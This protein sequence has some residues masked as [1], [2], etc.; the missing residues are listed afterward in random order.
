MSANDTRTPHSPTWSAWDALPNGASR[1]KAAKV[2][3]LRR[4]NEAGLFRTLRDSRWRSRRL[5]ILAY[6]GISLADEHEWSP[7]LYLPPEAIRARFELI[8]SQGYQ[9]LPLREAVEKLRA[10]TLPPRALAITFDDGTRDF[11]EAGV[12][13]LREFNYP[14]TVYVTSYYAEKQVPVFRM[15]ARY[16]VWRGRDR[17][18]SGEGLTNDG[19]PLDLHTLDHRDAAVQHMVD[20]LEARDGGVDDEL[21]TLRVLSARVGV[22]FDQ[23]LAE[24]RQQIMSPAEIRSL[25]SDL[26]EV[27][28]HTHRH[29]VP[30]RKASFDREIEDNRRALGSFRVGEKLDAFC[31]PSG[32][33]D[34]RFLPWLNELSVRT[35]VTCEAGLATASTDPLLLPRL[36]DTGL[37]RLEFESWLSGVGSLIP[38]LRRRRRYRPAPVYD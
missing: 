2:W 6:H 26:V 35:A 24:R 32:V 21:A 17:Q 36:V 1:L 14:A 19:K 20:R 30:L 8:R 9:V 10:G 37:T 28:L 25:P 34:E 5:L 23:F 4:A 31:Y 16:L 27:Q 33:T 12:P 13:L 18:I 22:D 15:A 38:R 11:L 29:R 3:F 7:E